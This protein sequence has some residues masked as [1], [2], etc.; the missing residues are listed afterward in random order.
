MTPRLH[1][2][3]RS[4]S[5]HMC[6]NVLIVGF[7]DQG[8]MCRVDTHM[9]HQKWICC[10]STKVFWLF[11]ELSDNSVSCNG[12]S[13]SASVAVN[14]K[15]LEVILML[16]NEAILVELAPVIILMHVTVHL[17]YQSGMMC[18]KINTKQWFIERSHFNLTALNGLV[19]DRAYGSWTL[20][21]LLWT[22][23]ISTCACKYL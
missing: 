2:F 10:P 7:G 23:G 13:L 14:K 21:S 17:P 1:G 15:I 6:I 16:D 4:R 5:H 9:S 19:F 22:L 18:S 8:C 12:L 3:I 11:D 20:S